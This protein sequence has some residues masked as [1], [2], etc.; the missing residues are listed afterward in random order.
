MLVQGGSDEE[1]NLVE[2]DGRGK[3]DSDVDAERDV[4]VQVAGRM[5]ID[6]RGI[7]VCFSQ[8]LDD[9]PYDPVDDVLRD[10]NADHGAD[11]NGVERIDNAL[12]KLAEVL[13]KSHRSGGL[14]RRRGDRRA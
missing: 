5:R 13:E 4:S 12:A 1:P 9:W 2:N 11:T 14:F 7:K 6:Q 8:R 10:V 3:D